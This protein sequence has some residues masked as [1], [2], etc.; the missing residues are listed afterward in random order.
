LLPLKMYSSMRYTCMPNMKYL[1]A[2]VQRL[3]FDL[4]G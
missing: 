3:T 1:Y 2:S 4:E